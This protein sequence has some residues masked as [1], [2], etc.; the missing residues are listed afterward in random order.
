MSCI[1]IITARGGSKRIPR[2][3]IKNFLG[4]PIIKYSLDAA[5]ESGCF[6]EIMVSTDDD[7]IASIAIEMGARVPFMRSENTSNDFATTAEV[8]NEVLSNYEA[9]GCRYKYCCCIY[10]TAPFLT[11]KKINAAY[12]IIEETDADSVIP[13]VRYS[14]PIQRSFGIEKG[15]LKMNWP[16]YTKTRSQDLEPAYYDSGQFYFLKVEAF[17]NT[18]SLFTNNTVPLIV[19]EHEVQDID[20]LSDWKSAETKFKMLN[21]I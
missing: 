9:I 19:S 16:E 7:E 1:A 5:K 13:V 4:K 18:Q 15:L 10:P 6:D 3:N 11:G 8:I 14:S 21:N 17:L 12:K 20:N 2:K